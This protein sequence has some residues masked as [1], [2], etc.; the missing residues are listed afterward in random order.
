[1]LLGLLLVSQVDFIVGSFIIDESEHKFGVMGYDGKVF[2]L[3]S[4]FRVNQLERFFAAELF[5][6]NL[7]SD[8]HDYKDSDKTPSFF[9]VFGVFFPAVTGIVAGANLSGDLKDPASAIPKGT[10][11]AIASTYV[12]Y[13]TYALI[14]GAVAE[15]DASGNQEEYIAYLYNNATKEVPSFIDCAKRMSNDTCE[16]G[17]ANDQQVSG[18][19]M[20]LNR[21]NPFF[22]I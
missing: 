5:K 11:L 21:L 16:Y 20:S 22:S 3:L 17:S 18:F 19:L 2:L 1:M 7:H 10:L 4:N 9:A 13:I 8:Y 15:T 6:K 14:V 12:S